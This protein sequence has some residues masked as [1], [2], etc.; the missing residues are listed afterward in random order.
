MHKDEQSFTVSAQIVL[1]R[2][3]WRTQK[4]PFEWLKLAEE[5]KQLQ[6]HKFKA[7]TYHL[8]NIHGCCAHQSG[9]QLSARCSQA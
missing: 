1:Q 9:L 8:Y 4:P 7:F 3:Q 5:H 2:K 6:H